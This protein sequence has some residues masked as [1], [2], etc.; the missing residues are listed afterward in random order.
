M[1]NYSENN[2]KIKKL[3]KLLKRLDK[4]PKGEEKALGILRQWQKKHK[5]NIAHVISA[6]PLT[7]E[8]LDEVEKRLG[9]IIKDKVIAVNK[10]NKNILGGLKIIINSKIIDSSL[11]ARLQ[12]FTKS[13]RKY[14][15]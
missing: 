12:Q 4:Q 10:V 11:A 14:N 8:Q 7:E 5:T 2:P 9:L 13:G 6:V 1:V 3:I 15:D